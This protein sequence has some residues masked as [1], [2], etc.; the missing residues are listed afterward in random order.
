MESINPLL[1]ASTTVPSSFL[2]PYFKISFR[3]SSKL[4]QMILE[5]FEH[6]WL[7]KLSPH[8]YAWFIVAARLASG[9][10]GHV[11]SIMCLFTGLL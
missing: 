3:L 8:C 10:S 7:L 9:A 6:R 4:I 11:Y 5:V 1:I 2:Q